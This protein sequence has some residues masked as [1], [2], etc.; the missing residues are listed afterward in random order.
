MN[1]QNVCVEFRKTA[2]RGNESCASQIFIRTHIIED[3]TMAL[4]RR[5]MPDCRNSLVLCPTLTEVYGKIGIK[6]FHPAE[7]IR[8]LSASQKFAL[9]LQNPHVSATQVSRTSTRK[10]LHIRCT[11]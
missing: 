10:S 8:T 1:Q 5:S 2:G 3:S 11:T 6:N 9:L 7:L 4:E